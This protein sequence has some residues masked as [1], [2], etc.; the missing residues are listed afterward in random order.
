VAEHLLHAPQVGAS[1]EQVRRERVPEE[2]RVNTCRIEPCPVGETA[3]DQKRA[4][5]RERAAAGVEEEL[6]AVAAVEMRAP[7]STP[8]RSRPVASDTRSPAP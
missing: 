4:R 5:A 8:V 6:G 3:E 7:R 2:V 1:L